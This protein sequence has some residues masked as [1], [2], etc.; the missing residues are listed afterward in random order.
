[1]TDPKPPHPWIPLQI[2][3]GVRPR[4]SSMHS[5]MDIALR[6]S[7]TRFSRLQGHA[8]LESII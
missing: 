5:C 7:P 2:V 4:D 6:P 8:D 1:M 3:V